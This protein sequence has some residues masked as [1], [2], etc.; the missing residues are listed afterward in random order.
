MGEPWLMITY[1]SQTYGHFFSLG[2]TRDLLVISWKNGISHNFEMSPST[3]N[4]RCN[5]MTVECRPF[6][7]YLGN[8]IVTLV[9]L[10]Y[11]YI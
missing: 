9:A 4:Q 7:L 11:F 3:C 2:V 10:L 6:K 8:S 1:Q 5:L